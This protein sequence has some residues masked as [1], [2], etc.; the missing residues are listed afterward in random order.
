MKL[1]VKDVAELLNCSEKTIY[2]WAGKGEIPCYRLKDQYRFSKA[3]VLE[4]AQSRRMPISEEA[5]A[6]PE[7]D[8]GP[9]PSFVEALEAGGI[10]YR[11][12]GAD[13]PAALK[14]VV[15]LLRLPDDVDRGFLHKILMAREALG[16]TG[17]GEGIAIPHVRNPIVLNVER[18]GITL[19]FLEKPIEFDAIDG[20]PVR[21]LFT[22]ISPTVRTHLHLLSR[23][24]FV[25]RD[26]AFKK[27]VISEA[28]RD[29]ILA[30][31]R[32]AEAA[33]RGGGA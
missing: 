25:M 20:Q 16:S 29:E 6:A 5:L 9:L 14:S 32:R 13:K 15:E 22:I 3:E 24:A 21:V 31:A 19:C 2:R 17:I 26:E 8:A 1:M 27:A 4:W 33:V 11:I 10:Y 7:G 23:L 28:S 30:Q 18:P 12:A